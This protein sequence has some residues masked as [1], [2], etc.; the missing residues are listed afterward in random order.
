MTVTVK[1]REDGEAGQQLSVGTQ[2]RTPCVRHQARSRVG[3]RPSSGIVRFLS[4]VATIFVFRD[5]KF[6]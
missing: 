5:G 4:R 6:T 3:A 2:L 1:K